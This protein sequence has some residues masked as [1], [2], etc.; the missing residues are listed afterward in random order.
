M[1]DLRSDAAF[2]WVAYGRRVG[3]ESRPTLPGVIADPRLE[4]RLHD[5]A[6]HSLIEPTST[7]AAPYLS[8]DLHS[9]T[10]ADA[11]RLAHKDNVPAAPSAPTP[12]APR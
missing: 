9:D 3:Y 6:S 7:P 12:T 10:A 2:T 11:A 5:R 1:A 4:A 8:N